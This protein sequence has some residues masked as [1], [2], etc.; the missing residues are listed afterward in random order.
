MPDP[1]P[2]ASTNSDKVELTHILAQLA[3]V[4]AAMVLVYFVVDQAML[5][6][7]TAGADGAVKASDV[8][9]VIGAVTTFLGTAIGLFFGVSVGQAGTK[10]AKDAAQSSQQNA[11]DSANVT[12]QA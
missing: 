6:L 12:Q 1:T 5:H 9:A 10:I 8:V 11:K 4:L 3:T 2:K 7:K